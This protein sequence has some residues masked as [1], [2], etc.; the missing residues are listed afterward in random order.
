MFQ[1]TA[2]TVSGKFFPSLLFVSLCLFFKHPYLLSGDFLS[3]VKTLG[4]S[5]YL[6]LIFFSDVVL[7]QNSQSLITFQN[8]VQFSSLI[9]SLV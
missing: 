2:K 3:P 9:M 1:I 6:I 5:L 4:L 7:E 8:H